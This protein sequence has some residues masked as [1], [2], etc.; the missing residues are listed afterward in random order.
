MNEN[1]MEK[2]LQEEIDEETPVEN[3]SDENDTEDV[4]G[5]TYVVD[6]DDESSEDDIDF[7]Y[8]EDGNVVIPEDEE[9]SEGGEEVPEAEDKAEEEAP[10]QVP[11]SPEKNKP[12]DTE[13]AADAKKRLAAYERQVKDTLKRYGYEGDDPLKGLAQIAADASGQDLEEYLAEMDKKAAE[14]AKK[15]E[16]FEA[17]A[18]SDLEILKKEYPELSSYKHITDMPK[19]IL[20]EFAKNRGMGLDAKKAYAAANPDGIRASA[21]ET[22]KRNTN[23]DSKAHLKSSV[24]KGSASESETIPPSELKEWMGMF[25]K[26]SKREVAELYKKTKTK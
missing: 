15:D 26:L 21:A 18:K 22:A 2:D 19:D 11:T 5:E 23:R 7:E 9:D 1:E 17:L 25:P 24:P 3:E 14:E 16:D 6:G 10:D 4:E 12:S 8:D 20:A 13:D